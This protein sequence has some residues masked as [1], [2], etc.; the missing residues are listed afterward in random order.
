METNKE[1]KIEARKCNCWSNKKRCN[2]S[3]FI[4]LKVQVFHPN[5]QR[6]SWQTWY[7]CSEHFFQ[8]KESEGKDWGC[9]YR[10]NEKPFAPV[11]NYKIV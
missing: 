9:K 5:T 8:F 11:I 10:N 3:L 6:K 7:M 2:K 4:T 1:I